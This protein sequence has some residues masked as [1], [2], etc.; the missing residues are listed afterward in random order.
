MQ[1][2]LQKKLSLFPSQLTFVLG[3][4]AAIGSFIWLFMVTKDSR[5]SVY[6]AALLMGGGCSIMLVTSLAM[7]ADLIGS[8]KVSS[9]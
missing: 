9:V 4:L 1:L 3:C 7:T 2:K 5:K 8:H 6:V